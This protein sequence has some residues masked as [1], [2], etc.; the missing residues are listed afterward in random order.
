MKAIIVAGGFGTRLK[1]LTDEVPKSMV[2]IINTPIMEYII[3]MLRQSG[4]TDIAM[5]LG[6]KSEFITEHFK[7]GKDFGVNITYYIEDTPLGTGGALKAA[8]GFINGGTAAAG[9]N[10]K[11]GLEGRHNGNISN[12]QSMSTPGNI[13]ENA[14]KNNLHA[15]LAINEKQKIGNYEDD[16]FL[17]MNGDAFTDVNLKEFLDFHKAKG[18]IGTLLL[19]EVEDVTGFGVVKLDK[20]NIITQ[21]IEKPVNSPEK[22]INAGIYMLKKEFLDLLPDGKHDISKDIFPKAV[23]KIAGFVTDAYWND[24][25]TLK[26]YYD[27][28]LYVVANR[29]KF[30]ETIRGL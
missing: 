18:S 24:I 17:M 7:D 27:T 13:G 3:N 2:K 28:N 23:G 14:E 6:H 1:P 26:A 5:A 29:D 8:S 9:T 19:K 25:G 20:N 15:S 30:K 10:F 21:F 22:L 16:D 12:R 4:F 11:D